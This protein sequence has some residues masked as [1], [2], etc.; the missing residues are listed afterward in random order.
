MTCGKVI[1][2]AGEHI[3]SYCTLP[4][5]HEGQCKY[6]PE[7]YMVQICKQILLERGEVVVPMRKR[8]AN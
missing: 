7:E 2:I 8:N 5:K 3:S 6:V 1:Y 4:E